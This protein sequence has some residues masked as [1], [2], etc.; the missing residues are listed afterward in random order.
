MGV[1]CDR[2]LA[3]ISN[4]LRIRFRAADGRSLGGY[5]WAGA[6]AA[7]HT[8][9]FLCGIAS[10]Q[11]YL[12]WLAEYL[13]EHGFGVLTF[14]YRGIGESADPFSNDP[15]V[16]LDEW[17]ALDLPAAVAE[18]RRRSHAG[19]LTVVAHSIG[20]QLLGQSP[21]RAEIDAVLLIASQRS[22]PRLFGGVARLRLSVGYLLLP[23]VIRLFGHLPACR[24][25]FPEHC[26]GET[27][28]QLARWSRQEAFTDD[29]GESV[30]ARFSDYHGPLLAIAISDDHYYAPPHAVRA[31]TDLYSGADVRLETIEP[32]SY[33]LSSIG[34][35]GLFRQTAPRALWARLLEYLQDFEAE[36]PQER[37]AASA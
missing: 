34:H 26:P 36:R 19:F 15:G 11:R 22:I 23:I 13:A 5:W 7:E 6:R 1:E 28:L 8:V 16:T 35:R 25:W 14:D 37:D 12:R 10:P 4:P 18:A 30:E 21:I 3:E 31:L 2:G 20:G 9:V 27:F 32:R 17:V 33:G 29:C 24:W